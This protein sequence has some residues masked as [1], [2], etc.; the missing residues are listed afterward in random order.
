MNRIPPSTGVALA[1]YGLLTTAAFASSGSPGGAYSDSAVAKYISFDHFWVAAGLWYLSA[2]GGLALLVVAHGL[3]QQ[4]RV[5]PLLAGLATV[6]AAVSLV[7]AFVSGGLAVAMAEGGGAVRNGVPHPAVYTITEIGN[8]LAVCA[9]ALC[10]GIIAIVLAVRA[11]LPRWLREFSIG[12]GV[13]G[14]LAPFFFTYFVFVL[15]TIVAGAAL[16]AR[17]ERVETPQ[18]LPS[19]V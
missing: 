17:R 10:T 5:G 3:R 12:A 15:W 11:A 7:G 13:C 1:G 9:P 4:P 6:G 18:P 19:L 14:I 8:L 2:V 16:A